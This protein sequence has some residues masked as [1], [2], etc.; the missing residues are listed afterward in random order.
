MDAHQERV[1]HQVVGLE[2]LDI[3]AHDL[4][5]LAPVLLAESQPDLLL[6]HRQQVLVLE[7]R[8]WLEV[9]AFDEAVD[10]GAFEIEDA[11]DV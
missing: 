10:H 11:E 3:G 7:S 1:V 2:D 5:N 9:F 6:V 8:R 4:E